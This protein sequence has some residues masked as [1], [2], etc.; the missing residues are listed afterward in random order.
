MQCDIRGSRIY[1]KAIANPPSLNEIAERCRMAA[2]LIQHEGDSCD[3][4][5]DLEA[6]A[7]HVVAWLDRNAS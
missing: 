2:T 7:C 1:E 5:A 6:L 3:T 4:R